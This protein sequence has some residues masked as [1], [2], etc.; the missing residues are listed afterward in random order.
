MHHFQ[1]S[2]TRAGRRAGQAAA[3]A[4]AV[5]CL[6][7]PA[8]HAD[9]IVYIDQ[10]NVVVSKPDGSGKVQLTDGGSWHSPTQADDGTIAAVQGTGPIQVMARD[11]RPIRTITTPSAKSGDGGTFAPRPVELA[12]SPDG[13]KIAYAYVAH[14][15][16]VGSTCG[17]IQRSTF[18]TDANVT[19]ATPHTVY[20]NQFGVA[21]PSWVTNSRTL[22]SGGYGSQVAID[23]LGPGDYSQIPWMVPNTDMGDPEVTRDGT[24]LAATFGYGA[25]TLIAFFAVKGDI[26]TESPPPLPDVAC[27]TDP[28]DAAYANPSWSPDGRGIAYESSKGIEIG[29]FTKLDAS[30]CETEPREIVLS[31]TGSE[32]D[33]GPADP[34]AARWTP[35]AAGGGRLGV[36]SGKASV[37]ALRKGLAVKVTAPGRGTLTV[38]LGTLAKT[39]KK[40]TKAGKVTVRLP[41]VPRGKAAKARGRK[42]TLSV[43][44]APAT[45]KAVT[46]KR[47]VRIR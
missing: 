33:W 31:A 28:P 1:S 46:A 37:A 47:T 43:R 40:V 26:K 20:G 39:T 30:G 13:T 24:R 16:P 34:P 45:G 21:A 2:W 12:F 35:P 19:E 10:G 22:V 9:S 27:N 41:K 25:D 42:V 6:A 15:C 11:G 3:I 8:A 36:S 14:S 23:D 18:Y 44:Y 7:V 4:T 38:K 17:T 5:A 29:Y 32:P